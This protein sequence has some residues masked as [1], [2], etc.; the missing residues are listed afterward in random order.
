MSVV[1]LPVAETVTAPVVVSDPPRPD[2]G[3]PY[4]AAEG[5]SAG[6]TL[7][8]ASLE[9]VAGDDP[10]ATALSQIAVG[11]LPLTS[12]VIDSDVLSAIPLANIEVE[13]IP[14]LTLLP[15]SSRLVFVGGAVV[16]VDIENRPCAY[17]AQIID[18]HYPG[19]GRRFIRAAMH[20]RGVTAWVEREGSVAPGDEFTVFFPDQ[21]PHP[22]QLAS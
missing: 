11:A 13:G 5:E 9:D 16:T 8:A 15:P 19:K 2:A 7:A 18:G 10:T 21:A 1:C 20:R 17:P 12:I 14:Q 3:G 4:S 6:S 22:D